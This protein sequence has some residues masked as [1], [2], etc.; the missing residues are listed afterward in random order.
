MI[1]GV[2]QITW[3]KFASKVLPNAEQ[4][5]LNTG[6][7]LNYGAIVTAV[8]MD[9]PPILQWDTEEARNPFS[10]YVYH[11]GST[12]GDWSLKPRVWTPVSGI[13]LKPSMW[14]NG[15]AFERMGSGAML[16]LEGAKDTRNN[17]MALFPE[18]LKSE[19]HQIRST[20]EMFSKRGKLEGQE[21]ASACGL[22][23][24]GDAG[25]NI[26]VKTSLG[27]TEYRIDRWD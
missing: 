2:Q 24:Q 5:L 3:V 15:N 26:R 14:Q 20:I 23:L 10:W 17:S 6:M 21:E 19:L 11:G 12:P 8:D 16:I 22:F 7:H 9:A 27:T 18:I 13:C 4:I 25:T 1:G